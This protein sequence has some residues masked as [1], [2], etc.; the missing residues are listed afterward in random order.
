MFSE[1]IQQE[2][3]RK[4]AELRANTVVDA[5]GCWLY[6]RV[7]GNGYGYL[8]STKLIK[9]GIIPNTQDAH[10]MSYLLHHG[11][12]PPGLVVRHK[13]DVMA[14]ANPD[15]LELGT[16]KQNAEDRKRKES[17]MARRGPNGTLDEIRQIQADYATGRY[18]Q[19]ELADKYGRSMPTIGKY[20][21]Q[22]LEPEHEASVP[23]PAQ[24]SIV[25]RLT[26]LQKAYDAGLIPEYDYKRKRSELVELF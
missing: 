25:E 24:P 16:Y 14:C 17:S 18:T 20:L 9:A 10:R 13:C 4:K 22:K 6:A 19:Q 23:L 8:H 15:H 21:R 26:E 5:N 11:P 2:I 12:I 3:E 7:Q 1:E